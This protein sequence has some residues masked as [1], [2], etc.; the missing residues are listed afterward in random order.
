MNSLNE[1][2]NIIPGLAISLGSALLA[3]F[4]AALMGV[5]TS[6]EAAGAL[7]SF[8]GAVAAVLAVYLALLEQRRQEIVK[9]SSAIKTEVASMATY[10]IQ[11]VETCQGVA[12]GNQPIPSRDASYIMRKLWKDPVVYTAMADRI[13]LLPHPN[14]TVQFYMRLG[15]AKAMLESLQTKTIREE[16]SGPAKHELIPPEFNEV[17]ADCLV[18]ALILARAILGRD[19]DSRMAE[20]VGLVMVDQID[21]CLRSARASFP[22]LESFNPP[23]TQA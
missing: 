15:E 19:R 1:R 7:G 20:W 13:G 21:Q 10:I 3:G 11:A 23:V 22:D 8:A 9:V 5:K 2:P 4:F 17:V 18:T 6:A 16:A 12:D 14:A